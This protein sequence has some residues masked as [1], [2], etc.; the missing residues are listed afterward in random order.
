MYN[1][2]N[3]LS[4]F[5]DIS[6]L[7]TSSVTNMSDMFSCCNILSSLLDIS[8][9]NTSNVINMSDMFCFYSY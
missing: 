9:W 1:D 3:I 8:K 6:K 2:C 4:S 7:N 5:S